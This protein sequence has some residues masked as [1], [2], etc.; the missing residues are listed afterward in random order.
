MGLVAHQMGGFDVEKTR[1]LFQIP[2][3][4]DL[5]SFIAIGY[6]LAIDKMSEASLIKE[7][8]AR[9]RKPLREIFFINQWGEKS[10]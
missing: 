8:E 1:Q 6:P 2:S 9:K 3:Q 5:M 7:K 10:L 4:Y